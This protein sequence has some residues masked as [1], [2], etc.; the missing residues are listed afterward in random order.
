MGFDIHYWEADSGKLW[1][2]VRVRL[3]GDIVVRIERIFYDPEQAINHLYFKILNS[4]NNKDI[5][6][7]SLRLF[8]AV[9]SAILKARYDQKKFLIELKNNLL[10]LP[11]WTLYQ[12]LRKLHPLKYSGS[13]VI[14]QAGEIADEIVRIINERIK[15][16][17]SSLLVEEKILNIRAGNH[18]I[19]VIGI[20]ENV[21]RE[22]LNLGNTENQAGLRIFVLRRHEIVALHDEHKNV[23][24]EIPPSIIV[25][26]ALRAGTL[27]VRR[28][29]FTIER[30]LILRAKVRVIDFCGCGSQNIF[31]QRIVRNNFGLPLEV[32]IERTPLRVAGRR[33][34]LEILIHY[35]IL[36]SPWD[37]LKDIYSRGSLFGIIII[38]DSNNHKKIISTAVNNFLKNMKRK[39]P[40]LIL[41]KTKTRKNAEKIISDIK[42]L[43]E[44][45]K[46]PI[47]GIIIENLGE[48]RTY[49]LALARSLV[50]RRILRILKHTENES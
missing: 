9:S 14:G 37:L 8:R 1:S 5:K 41:I 27:Q 44:N 35:S 22:R 4:Y 10:M 36:D 43:S 39:I 23:S 12:I 49:L 16:I 6:R 2:G 33:G 31:G 15:N 29:V 38:D 42:A 13:R 26:D 24:L 17:L 25:L 32:L 50:T 47:K 3:Q 7:I 48:I 45:H 40:V 11:S 21:I 20:P 30:I 46:L 18:R 28:T 34:L 19:K